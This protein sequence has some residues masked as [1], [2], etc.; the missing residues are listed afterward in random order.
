[1]QQITQSIR[2]QAYHAK[3]SYC[4]YGAL[5]TFCCPPNL[6][7]N[8]TPYDSGARGVTIAAHTPQC[9]ASPLT[10]SNLC[11]TRKQ[12]RNCLTTCDFKEL[13]GG[14]GEARTPDLRF[15]NLMDI[16]H[17][18]CFQSIQ[19]GHSPALSGLVGRRTCNAI[20]NA[21]SEPI[22]FLTSG[23][24]TGVATKPLCGGLTQ[25]VVEHLRV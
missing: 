15:R 20:C 19:F 24:T 7:N 16:P 14:A 11:L 21:L 3:T 23:K 9:L 1:M 22:G 25:K 8:T 2:V 17:P 12:N 4:F 6:P 5:S 10:R 18:V 13:N